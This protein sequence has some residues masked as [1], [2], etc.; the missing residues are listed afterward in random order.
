MAQLPERHKIQAQSLTHS[1][2]H[3]CRMSVS[4]GVRVS[5][6]VCVC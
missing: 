5:L 4:A 1:H 6:R 3:T 2:K